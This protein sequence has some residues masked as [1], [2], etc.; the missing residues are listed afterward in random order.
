[1]SGS[2]SEAKRKGKGA[3]A[4][5]LETATLE[6]NTTA[7]SGKL[8]YVKDESHESTSA[9]N[10]LTVHDAHTESESWSNRPTSTGLL[11]VVL[12]SSLSLL[13]GCST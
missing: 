5:G 9:Q 3:P 2:L 4:V 13:E 12:R 6:W 7:M 1:V 11:F 10:R 8:I